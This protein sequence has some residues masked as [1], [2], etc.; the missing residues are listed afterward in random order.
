ML[1]SSSVFCSRGGLDGHARC[2]FG[3]LLLHGRK[4][5]LQSSV[6]SHSNDLAE[7]RLAFGHRVACATVAADVELQL[8]ML[9]A[10][11]LNIF[12]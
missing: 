9:Q 8:L 5:L 7:H 10:E 1:C 2:E 4:V 6:S 12:S 11:A 3:K